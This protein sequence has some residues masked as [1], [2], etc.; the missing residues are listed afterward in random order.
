M[1]K[2]MVD[3]EVYKS[4]LTDLIKKQ[5]VMLG[6]NVAL[7]TARKV[8]G[9]TVVEDGTVSEITADPQAV[10]EG[11]TNAY[12]NLSGQIAQMTLKTVL[13]KYPTLKRPSEE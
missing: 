13:E 8:S 7:G 3:V 12:M 1:C 5:M 6:P 10:V 4:M 9:L 11:V 2:N